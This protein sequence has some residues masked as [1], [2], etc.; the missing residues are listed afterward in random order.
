MNSHLYVRQFNSIQFNSIQFN[1]HSIEFY[2]CSTISTTGQV[3]SQIKSCTS[4]RAVVIKY[5][6]ISVKLVTHYVYTLQEDISII[7]ASQV[8]KTYYTDPNTSLN[9]EMYYYYYFIIII[10]HSFIFHYIH[11]NLYYS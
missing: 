7:K 8:S 2:S 1:S 6:Q 5:K 11:S 9:M 10:I 4:P 3:T